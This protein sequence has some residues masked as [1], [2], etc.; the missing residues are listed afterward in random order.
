MSPRARFWSSAVFL[1]LA[2]LI[3]RIVFLRYTGYDGLY[4]QD[5]YAY[6]DYLVK[7]HAAVRAGQLPPPFHWPLG[8]PALSLLFSIF[9]GPTALA[10]Q[11]AAVFAGAMCAPLMFALAVQCRRD[12]WLPAFAA[13][14]L[15]DTSNYAI[16]MSL[17]TMSDLPGL[18]WALLAAIAMLRYAEAFQKRWLALAA[19]ALAA[20]LLTRWVYAF[21]VVPLGLA[22]LTAYAA[23]RPAGRRIAGHAALAVG[24]GSA[25]LALHFAP[26]LLRGDE[27]VAYAGNL[28]TYT[29][30]PANFFKTEFHSGDGYTAWAQ[31]PARYYLFPLR[32]GRY[33]APVFAPLLLFGLLALRRAPRP[34]SVLLLSWLL[35]FYLFFAGVYMQNNRFPLSYLPPLFALLAL[36]LA[37]LGDHLTTRRALL[38]GGGVLVLWLVAQ[39]HLTPVAI[40][41]CAGLLALAAAWPGTARC[42]LAVIALIAATPHLHRAIID[43]HYTQTVVVPREIARAHW[44]ASQVPPDRVILGSGNSVV[45]EHNAPQRVI[46]LFNLTT[47]ERDTLL[48]RDGE[49]YIA[50]DPVALEKQWSGL[51]PMEHFAWLQANTEMH[52]V[53]RQEPYRVF[54]AVLRPQP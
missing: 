48:A 40:A 49:V 12:A 41:A 54:R 18:M 6:H 29:W 32:D 45:L 2:G 43:I 51:R 7:L 25:V 30:S 3:F 33:V 19:F 21:M 15:F 26:S 35:V 27:S 42:V 37:W 24:V 50:L 14:V 28:R 9:T 36:G 5:P 8:Y 13:A 4:G 34:A 46:D 38:V 17:S 1:F 44:I 47:E 10:S 16:S 11:A 31:S 20:A 53:A 23:Q 39:S 52:E 22:A